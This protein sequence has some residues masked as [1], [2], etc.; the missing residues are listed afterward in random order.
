MVSV[1][2]DPAIAVLQPLNASEIVLRSH[3]CRTFRVDCSEKS[4]HHAARILVAIAAEQ[5]LQHAAVCFIDV[6]QR[7]IRTCDFIHARVD[8]FGR[9]VD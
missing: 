6:G 9:I 1:K 4:S 7:T 5:L 8:L 3:V 2:H